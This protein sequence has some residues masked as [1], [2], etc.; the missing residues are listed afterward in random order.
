MLVSE[1]YPGQ[2]QIMLSV[3]N[4]DDD[5][6]S[7]PLKYILPITLILIIPILMCAGASLPVTHS[8]VPPSAANGFRGE[9]PLCQMI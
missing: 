9:S 7:L 1:R 4:H 8:Y 2:Q 5:A 6:V 3:L